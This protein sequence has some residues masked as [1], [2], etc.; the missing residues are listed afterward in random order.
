MRQVKPIGSPVNLNSLQEYVE[1]CSVTKSR[2]AALKHTLVFA[3]YISGGTP[4]PGV[5]NQ[6]G[7]LYFGVL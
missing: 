6:H 4:T 2:I 5:Y 7:D 1:R 3:T